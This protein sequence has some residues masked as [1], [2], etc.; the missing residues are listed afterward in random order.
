MTSPSGKQCQEHFDSDHS[1]QPKERASPANRSSNQF[2]KRDRNGRTRDLTISR[3]PAVAV[4][5]DSA[6]GSPGGRGGGRR[7]GGPSTRKSSGIGR[8]DGSH[9]LLQMD[10]S[11]CSAGLWGEPPTYQYWAKI[12]PLIGLNLWASYHLLVNVFL[13]FTCTPAA[14]RLTRGCPTRQISRW[15]S[16]QTDKRPPVCSKP[17]IAPS[18]H[19]I[20]RSQP[21]I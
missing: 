11:I 12:G 17:F 5:G 14:K 20:A 1:S 16:C 13:F 19:C 9:V 21:C 15:G 3:P 18:L 8:T 4:A 10:G 7:E 6:A 2:E